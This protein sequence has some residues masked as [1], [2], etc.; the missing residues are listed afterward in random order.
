MSLTKKYFN[1]GGH[2]NAAGGSLEDKL[3]VALGKIF[4]GYI[5]TFKGLKLLIWKKI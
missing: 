5:K 1:G 3:S 2:K 4:K